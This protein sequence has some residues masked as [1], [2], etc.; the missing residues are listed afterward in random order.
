MHR[1]GVLNFSSK[2]YS[3]LNSGLLLV[4]N[5]TNLN[6]LSIYMLPVFWNTF[7]PLLQI[8]QISYQISLLRKAITDHFSHPNTYSLIFGITFFSNHFS[9]IIS[10]FTYFLSVSLNRNKLLK[11]EVGLT[12]Y[13][14][15]N[16]NFVKCFS[17][18]KQNLVSK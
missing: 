5:I 10:S 12:D 4:S 8:I 13:C 1:S 9:V 11:H 7:Y 6:L 18:F 16:Q 3:T 2:H 15:F 17:F 14:M